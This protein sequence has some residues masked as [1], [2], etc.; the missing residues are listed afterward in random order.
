ME[1]IDNKHAGLKNVSATF[2]RPPVVIFIGTRQGLGLDE[3]SVGLVHPSAILADDRAGND[4]D[5]RAGVGNDLNVVS[6]GVTTRGQG[7]ELEQLVRLG[8]GLRGLGGLFF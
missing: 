3:L 4:L 7:L 8:R 2:F 1:I 6:R 5:V